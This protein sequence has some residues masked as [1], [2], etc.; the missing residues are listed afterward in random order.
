MDGGINYNSE[1]FDK[2][3]EVD[4]KKEKTNNNNGENNMTEN[5]EVTASNL[6]TNNNDFIDEFNR[7][8]VE[9]EVDLTLNEIKNLFELLNKDMTGEG[10]SLLYSNFVVKNIHSVFEEYKIVMENLYD[11]RKDPKFLEFNDKRGQLV[12]VY[13]DRDDQGNILF[14]E[15]KNPIITEKLVE[16]KEELDKLNEE[17]KSVIEVIKNKDK[18]NINYLNNKKQIKLFLFADFYRIPDKAS[19]FI[20]SLHLR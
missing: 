18:Y 16:F 2:F 6:K 3:T 1:F 17:Y 14:D 11:E 8:L 13:S 9:T 15:N 19:P 4:V 5:K 12:Q 7:S 10:L 20:L